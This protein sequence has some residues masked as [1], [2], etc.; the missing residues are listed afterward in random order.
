MGVLSPERR[1]FIEMVD[2]PSTLNRRVQMTGYGTSLAQVGEQGIF[3]LAAVHRH[4]ASRVKAA[5]RRGFQ[6][7][8]HF[9]LHDDAFAHSLHHRV[10]DRHSRHQSLG[11]GVHGLLI[12]RVAGSNFDDTA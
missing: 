5:T 1:P 9:A 4:R 7:A 3:V 2:D 11:V 6:G 8:R 10:G 12:E